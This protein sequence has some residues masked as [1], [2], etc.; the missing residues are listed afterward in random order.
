M[1]RLLFILS[2]LPI[3]AAL[4]AQWWFGLRV[5]AAEGKR[6][7][8]CELN[9]W[10]HTLGESPLITTPEAPAVEFGKQLRLVAL[11]E[12]KIRDPKSATSRENSRRFGLAVPPLT[13]LIAVFALVLAKIPALGA[14]TILLASTAISA[15][16]GLLTLPPEL[17][18]IS[19]TTRKM[20][21]SRVFVRT[22]DEEAVAKSAIAHAWRESIPPVLRWL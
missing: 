13:L 4:V 19:R 1:W 5:I 17:L 2:V 16:I 10:N 9:R 22:D 21:E 12:W 3:A 15:A 18:A 6:P 7:C 14:I 11:E 20:R 8:R